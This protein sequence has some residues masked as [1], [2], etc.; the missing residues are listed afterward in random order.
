MYSPLEKMTFQIIYII[1]SN[2]AYCLAYQVSWWWSTLWSA[3]CFVAVSTRKH[4]LSEWG[5][6]YDVLKLLIGCGHMACRIRL[7]F[8]LGIVCQYLWKEKKTIGS[9]KWVEHSSVHKISNCS[10]E[11][12]YTIFSCLYMVEMLFWDNYVFNHFF[13]E[14]VFEWSCNHSVLHYRFFDC[15]NA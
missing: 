4:S 5:G 13:E 10:S 15:K 14:F 7:H 3:D 2:T 6:I 9:H 8:L 1:W 11:N 12:N